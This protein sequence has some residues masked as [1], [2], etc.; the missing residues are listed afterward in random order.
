M[1]MIGVRAILLRP[2][3]QID[4]EQSQLFRS[5]IFFGLVQFAGCRLFLIIIFAIPPKLIFIGL[6]AKAHSYLDSTI[7]RLKRRMTTN[8][9]ANEQ[10]EMC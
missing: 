5:V 2:K 4:A 10:T 8:Q 1:M 3:C 6:I 7:D 9:I